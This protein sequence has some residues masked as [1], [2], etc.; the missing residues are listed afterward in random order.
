MIKEEDWKT[1]HSQESYGSVGSF[2]FRIQVYPGTTK[3]DLE[4][5]AR[6]SDYY[7]L[8][9]KLQEMLL[10]SHYQNSEKHR[11]A[12]M[13]MRDSLISLFDG[14]SIFIEDVPNEYST[15]PG[16]KDRPWMIVTTKIGHIK[17]G[18]RKNVIVIDWSRT[19][20]TKN[21]TILFAEEDVT[22]SDKMIHAWSIEKAAEYLDEIF[23]SVANDK[24]GVFL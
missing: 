12:M 4:Q 24:K 20:E 1:L 18:Y 14:R 3:I 7:Q 15:G 9:D 2:G 11:G 13:A 22:K 17:I 6:T 23:K 5:I 8:T 21:S 10:D 16:M 19:K